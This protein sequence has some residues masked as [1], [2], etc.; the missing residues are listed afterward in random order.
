MNRFLTKPLF[1]V[2]IVGVFFSCSDDDGPVPLGDYENGVIIVNEGNFLEGD[3]SLSFFS[4][5]GSAPDLNVFDAVNDRALGDIAQ[6]AYTY[7]TL[8]FVIVNNSNKVEVLHRYTMESLY[9]IDA[10]L[11]RYMTVANGKGYLTE[12]VSFSDQ[13][14]LSIVDLATGNIDGSITVGFGAEYVVIDG[15]TAYVSN[16]FENT[17]S[18]INLNTNTVDAT[19]SLPSPAPTQMAIDSNGDLWVACKGGFDDNFEPTNDGLIIQIDL[20]TITSKGAI[21]FNANISGKLAING[22]KDI[23]YFYTGNAVFDL[24]VNSTDSSIDPLFV[25]DAFTSL[26]GIGVDPSSGDVYVADSKNFIEDGEV[27]Q[28]D[29]NGTLVTSFDV[30]RG[31]NGFV[32]N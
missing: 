29:S 26:Y 18:E 4:N 8:L 25:N 20:S 28:Y 16:T 14:R 17:I 31:P 23:I 11:P 6:S 15:T 19:L 1:L 9:T 21:E 5:S 22:P 3:A 27:Y 10:A 24:D 32:F 7:D 12:W 2:L 13:G 30:G